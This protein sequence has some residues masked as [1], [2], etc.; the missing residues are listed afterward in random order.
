MPLALFHGKM[1]N[2]ELKKIISTIVIGCIPGA[3]GINKDKI[4]QNRR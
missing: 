4:A 2:S 1:I 3:V